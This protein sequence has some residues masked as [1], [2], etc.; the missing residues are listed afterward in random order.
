MIFIKIIQKIVP[1]HIFWLTF[2]FQCIGNKFQVLIQRV[3]TV[4]NFYELHEQTNNIILKVFIVTDWDNVI[5][6][7][8]K[9]SILI[10]IP[11]A[12]CISKT[13]HIQ[14]VA[15]K[16]TTNR[17]RNK[18]TNI[19]AKVSLANSDILV[20]NLRCQLILQAVNVDED[21]VQFFLVGFQLIET[22]VTLVLP[23]VKGFNNGRYFT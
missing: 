12:T 21:T 13:I 3:C 7:C 11:F 10:G 19:S 15:T 16:H 1:N 6:I 23:L 17:I 20:L 14:R 9:R 2:T 22:A 8:R 5:L 18:G 4:N